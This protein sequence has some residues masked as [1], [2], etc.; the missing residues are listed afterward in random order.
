MKH[1]HLQS[2]HL[3]V[4]SKH[5]ALITIQQATRNELT[6]LKP[7]FP[8]AVIATELALH[9]IF[10]LHI[11]IE[12][13]AHH[14]ELIGTGLHNHSTALLYLLFLAFG[15]E[16]TSCRCHQ[17]T[18]VKAFT[19]AECQHIVT[20]LH[21][22][23]FMTSIEIDATHLVRAQ[24]VSNQTTHLLHLVIAFCQQAMLLLQLRCQLTVLI[25]NAKW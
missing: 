6:I 15:L 11:G 23:G 3:V 5:V 1:L 20:H 19:W 14:I 10:Q 9:T 2:L 21:R 13:I 4:G 22:I 25:V 16:T 17:R 7:A 8:D 24:V 18:N 12:A